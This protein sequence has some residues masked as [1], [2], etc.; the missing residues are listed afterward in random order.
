MSLSIKTRD[1]QTF[2]KQLSQALVDISMS[3]TCIRVQVTTFNHR[4]IPLLI[5][6]IVEA[7]P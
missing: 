6:H 7:L 5:S 1:L 2:F 4:L 3:D